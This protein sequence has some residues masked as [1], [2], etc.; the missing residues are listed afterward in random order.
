VR[1]EIGLNG[2]DEIFQHD[3]DEGQNND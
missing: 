2:Y 1:F 3:N